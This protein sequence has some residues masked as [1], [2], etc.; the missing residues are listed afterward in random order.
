MG[1][2]WGLSP[3]W[4]ANAVAEHSLK[5]VN[6]NQME[7]TGVRNVNTFDEQEIV[8]ETQQGFLSIAGEQLHITLL[9]LEEGKVAVEGNIG[10]IV[11]REQGS[12]M[13]TRSRN[14]LSRL[15]K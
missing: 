7:L 5:L 14:I 4:E 3:G 13:R 12:D 2:Q 10:S 15:L 9:N 11:Y 1:K 8:L 6:R